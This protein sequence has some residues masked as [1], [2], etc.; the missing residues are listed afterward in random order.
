[1]MRSETQVTAEELRAFVLS[2]LARFKVP[3][4]FIFVKD[5]PRNALGK[6]QHYRL[7]ESLPVQPR[8]GRA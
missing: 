2:Q 8:P 6:V 4:E 7:K 5:L 3:R 1:V